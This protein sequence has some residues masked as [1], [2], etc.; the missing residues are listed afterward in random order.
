MVTEF[1][2]SAQ[3]L[4]GTRWK[5]PLARKL[6][7]SRET[8]SRWITHDD[9]PL[10]AQNMVKLMMSH[11]GSVLSLCD[12][13][14]SMVQPWASAGYECFCID[15]QHPPGTTVNGNIMLIGDDIRT[16]LPPPRR[17]AIVFAFPPCSNLAVSGAAHFLA[18]GMGGLMDGIELVEACRRICEWSEAPWMIENPVSILASYW[19]QPDFRFDPWEFGGWPGGRDDGYAKRTCLWTGNGFVMPEERP[20]AVTKVNFIHHMS[21]GAD[22][23]NRR[24]ETPRG[25]ANAVFAANGGHHII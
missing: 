1:R 24:S 11:K 4:C 21:P 2:L 5:A 12:R 10:W 17:Y 3:V 19:R 22:R 15:Q 20:I 23:S 7:V 18:K 8:V 25:F 16:W 6:G 9:V 14:T 13:T